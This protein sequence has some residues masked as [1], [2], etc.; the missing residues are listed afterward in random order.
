MDPAVCREHLGSLLREES[1][2][3]EELEALLVHEG[4]VLAASD[5]QT[6]ETTTRA[7]QEKMGGLARLEEQRRSLC[8]MHGFGSDRA[9]LEAAM[10]WCDPAGSLLDALRR[11]AERAVRC[12]DLNDRNSIV[13][14]ARLKRVQSML[15]ALTGRPARQD[16]YGP[17]GHGAFGFQPGRSLGAA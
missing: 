1:A 16:T 3:L 9:G 4:R 17:K 10:Q 13:V 11:C 8:A 6:I 7:R 2:L 15:G 14:A 5:I 12:R